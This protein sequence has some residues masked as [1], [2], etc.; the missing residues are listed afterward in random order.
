MAKYCSKCGKEVNE[1]SK[2]CEGCGAPQNVVQTSNVNTNQK[3][4]GMPSW[5]IVLI[6][7]FGLAIFGSIGGNS[8]DNSNSNLGKKVSPNNVKVTFSEQTIYEGHDVVMK[9]TGSENTS[10]GVKLNIYVENNSNLNLNFNAH[11]YGVNG[12]M[13]R[14]NIYDMRTEVASGK[15]A[16]T[17]LTIKNSTLKE[18]GIDYIK[19]I[20][21][22]F[23]AYDNDKMFKSFETN[24]ITIK[25]DK[26][27]DK[28]SWME[29]KEIYNKSGIKVDY[30]SIN[31]DKIKYVVTNTTGNNLDL[32][33]EG[34]SINDYTVSDTD[35]DLFN[36]QVLNNNQI[37]FEI[38][39]KN[40]FKKENNIDKINKVDFYLSYKEN[41]DYHTHKTENMTTNID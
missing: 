6:V 18:Y 16:N 34:I 10:S 26:Y 11:S 4:K 37:I 13:T 15:K 17:T 19:Y 36:E 31:G 21:I 12:I 24:T 8:S 9:V 41:D 35:F 33:F 29:G 28:N 30:L 14:N 7:I 23:W 1:K 5:A 3:K 2:F 20:D 40:D 22:L 38:N 32:T 27:D 25:S 39:V